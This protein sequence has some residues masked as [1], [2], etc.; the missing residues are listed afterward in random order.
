MNKTE[1]KKPSVHTLTRPLPEVLG[2]I[3]KVLEQEVVSFDSY[4]E[5]A[6]T[7]NKRFKLSVTEDDLIKYYSASIEIQD[8]ELMYG[9]YGYG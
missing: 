1:V 3:L 5:M 2:S 6:N 9:R 4:S 8:A 7:I